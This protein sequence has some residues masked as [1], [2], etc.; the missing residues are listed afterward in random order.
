MTCLWLGLLS[1]TSLFY[2]YT[3]SHLTGFDRNL[4]QRRKL[5]EPNSQVNSSSL[6][7]SSLSLLPAK[8]RTSRSQQCK[9][10][11]A[12][13]FFSQTT[14][15][16]AML[17]AVTDVTNEVCWAM[18]RMLLSAVTNVTNEV[19]LMHN[20]KVAIWSAIVNKF[21]L[22]TFSFTPKITTSPHELPG[23]DHFCV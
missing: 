5:R 16:D 2:H 13:K 20:G 14:S 1:W 15:K 11:I 4:Q 19:Y 10:Y 8:S 18:P 9:I 3:I 21:V 6:S 22:N 17:S 12:K 7:S 23:N